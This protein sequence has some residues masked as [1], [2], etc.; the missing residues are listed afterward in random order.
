LLLDTIVRRR[1]LHALQAS[2]KSFVFAPRRARILESAPY[3]R[4]P[5]TQSVVHSECCCESVNELI[6]GTMNVVIAV[7]HQRRLLDRLQIGIA[8]ASWLPPS[9]VAACCAFIVRIDEGGSASLR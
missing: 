5:D 7:H 2:R 1:R 3:D 6:V 8:F 4:S 9:I